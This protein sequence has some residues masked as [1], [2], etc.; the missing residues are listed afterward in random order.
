MH[1]DGTRIKFPLYKVTE[2]TFPEGS[3]WAR[4]PIPG[5]HSCD[6]Y[7]TCGAP[8]PPVAGWSGSDWDDQVNCNAMCDGAADSKNSDGNCGSVA[9]QF[10]PQAEGYSGFGKSIWD[11][12]VLDKMQIPEDIESGDYVLSWRWDCEESTQV[13]QN[14][15]DITIQ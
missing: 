13:W 5:C 11:W 10:P 1:A 7:E 8:L 4:D 3:E 9:T 12:S 2:G 14:C 15:A 6:A